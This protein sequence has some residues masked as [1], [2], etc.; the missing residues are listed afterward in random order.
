MTLHAIFPGLDRSAD[1]RAAESVRCLG[2]QLI[3]S[4][5]T[6]RILIEVG[7]NV[8]LSGMQDSIGELCAR[9]LD[10]PPAIGLELRTLL[11]TLREEVDRI[12]D[13]LDPPTLG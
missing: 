8:D 4:L 11:L 2:T 10:L 9:A 6:A 13:A 3:A 12:G 7:R 5:S 1:H